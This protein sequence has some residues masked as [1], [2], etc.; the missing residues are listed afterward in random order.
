MKPDASEPEVSVESQSP[1]L[2]VSEHSEHAEHSEHEG[3]SE[4]SE[5]E[6]YKGHQE[7]QD[8]IPDGSSTEGEVN[9]P[10]AKPPDVDLTWIGR[11]SVLARILAR[12]LLRFLHI[13]AS[14]GILLLLAT[15][16]ALIW[17][18][19]PGS[20][21]YF[22]FWHTPIYLSFH[23]FVIFDRDLHAF[24]NDALMALFF[25]VVGL[26]IK[27]EMVSGQLSSLR[28]VLLPVGAA[29][30]GMIVPA[31]TYVAFNAGSEYIN[32]WGI[33]MATDIA[34]AIGVVSL[35]GKRVPPWLKLFL[36]SLAI[37]DDIGSIL[38]IAI[39]YS[40]NIS[41]GWL[42]AAFGTCVLIAVL[43]RIRVWHVPMYVLLGLIVWWT[44]FR[45]GVHATIAGVALGLLTPASPL[46]SESKARSVARWLERKRK[47][48][49]MDIR[50][51][52]FSITESRSVAERLEIILHPYVSYLIVPLFALANAGVVL[53]GE[54]LS[55][56]LTS[57]VTLGVVLG[58]VVG[59]TVGVTFF[60]WL[61]AKLKLGALPAG[62][63]YLHVLGVS[64]IAGIG[65]TVSLFVTVL[66]FEV[67]EP[68]H[69]GQSLDEVAYSIAA[70][71]GEAPADEQSST[72][73]SPWAVSPADD[74][75][76]V[77]VLAG[78]LIAFIGGL[79]VLWFA[80]SRKPESSDE[81]NLKPP[82]DVHQT[83]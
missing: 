14:G 73:V 53:S 13:E 3:H 44:T 75:A 25:F 20:D 32:G 56:A 58:L 10:P 66:A 45:S 26:E 18:N 1:P 17:V 72:A 33:P 59:K 54:L 4:H 80:C 8:A 23:D 71:D 51:A 46:Q 55:R 21:S 67:D 64:I 68:L 15:A 49:L 16:A 27:R 30:G 74:E 63:N 37:A 41:V 31:L 29:L 39:F 24:V 82:G 81:V 7:H 40:S 76:K 47:I 60:T 6:G 78:S 69:A 50:R 12:P 70:S 34:F 36:L 38:V 83:T 65:F 28:N 22:D 35:L 2:D 62:V 42:M 79:G 5:H 48:T 9:L 57:P 52:G 43:T 11:D 19:S 61:F 77:G